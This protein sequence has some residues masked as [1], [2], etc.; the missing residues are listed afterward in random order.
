[1]TQAMSQVLR[2]VIRTL[3]TKVGVSLELSPIRI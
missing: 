2:I 3:L 1:M